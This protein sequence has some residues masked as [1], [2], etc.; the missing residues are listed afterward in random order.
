MTYQVNVIV[1]RNR[2]PGLDGGEQWSQERVTPLR[3]LGR[4]VLPLPGLSAESPLAPALAKL[5]QDPRYQVLTTVNWLQPG[6]GYR[7]AVP[8]RIADAS[9]DLDGVI[10]VYKLLYLHADIDLAFAPDTT[11][12]DTAAEASSGGR[13]GPSP[14]SPGEPQAANAGPGE[15]SLV[16]RMIEHRRI[17]AGKVEYFDHP[18]F[19]VLLEVTPLKSPR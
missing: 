5:S 2:L 19:G 16:Y 1:F 13:S 9:G 8:V 15:S 10:T 17:S 3:R 11:V 6:V 7:Q 12:A 14:P 4:S 18:K